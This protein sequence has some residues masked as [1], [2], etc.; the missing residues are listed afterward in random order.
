MNLK[1]VNK[2]VAVS[3]LRP[4]LTTEPRFDGHSRPITYTAVVEPTQTLVTRY[5][6]LLMVIKL[7]ASTTS[8]ETLLCDTELQSDELLFWLC[9]LNLLTQS[10]PRHRHQQP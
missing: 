3:G 2:T 6:I 9:R 5:H 10:V 1:Q 4:T 7:T 8:A